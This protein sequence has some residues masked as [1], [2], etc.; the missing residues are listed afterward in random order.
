MVCARTAESPRLAIRAN[1]VV[2]PTSAMICNNQSAK[3]AVN[4]QLHAA[5]AATTFLL[6][7]TKSN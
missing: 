1:L 6:L 7:Y 4:P 3:A 5:F 2:G